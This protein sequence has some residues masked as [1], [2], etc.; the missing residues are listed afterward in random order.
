MVAVDHPGGVDVARH[1]GLRR[2]AFAADVVAVLAAEHIEAPGGVVLAGHQTVLAQMVERNQMRLRRVDGTETNHLAR[3][4]SQRPA[5]GDRRIS[6]HHQHRGQV[7]VGV[8]HGDGVRLLAPG[9]GHAVS[10]NPGQR[11]IP[12]HGDAA[13]ELRLD[14]ALV[15]GIQHVVKLEIVTPEILFEAFPDRHYFWRVSHC[16]HH[17]RCRHHLLLNT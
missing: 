13:V 15:V 16:A 7:A 11:R 17:Q 9:T 6:A 14:L 2:I 1:Q 5:A 10:P 4:I 3:Q 12:R 8:A